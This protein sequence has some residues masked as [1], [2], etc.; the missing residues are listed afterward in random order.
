MLTKQQ[1]KKIQKQIV[2]ELLAKAN[3]AEN[4]DDLDKS[5]END[6]SV[7]QTQDSN[8]STRRYTSKKV[9]F[10]LQKVFTKQ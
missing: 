5:I 7:P 4:V 10:L 3:A 8:D 6:G 1:L 9:R 2:R